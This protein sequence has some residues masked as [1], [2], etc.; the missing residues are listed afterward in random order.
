M[1]LDLLV[2]EFVDVLLCLVVLGGVFLEMGK[3]D[4]CDFGV[5]V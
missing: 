1:V 5:I 2:G 3:I 4:I